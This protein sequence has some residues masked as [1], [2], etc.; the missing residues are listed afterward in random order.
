MLFYLAKGLEILGVTSE[1]CPIAAEEI[2]KIWEEA[3]G[4]LRLEP[5]SDS[6]RQLLKNKI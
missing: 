1:T 4:I 3:D 2:R 5:V 6:Y